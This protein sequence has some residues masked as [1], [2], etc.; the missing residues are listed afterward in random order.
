M[1]SAGGPIPGMTPASDHTAP[2][3]APSQKPSA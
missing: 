3:S 2:T 1:K